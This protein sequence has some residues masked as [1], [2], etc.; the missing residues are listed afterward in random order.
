MTLDEAIAQLTA[1]RDQVGGAALLILAKDNEGN[2]FS[3]AHSFDVGMSAADSDYSGEHHLT[4]EQ[5]LAKEEPDE[6]KQA[7]A[8]AV[9]AV[10]AWPTN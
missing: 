3:P 10:F 5:R 2:G 9:T 4:E 8:D 1:L 7:P 6:H